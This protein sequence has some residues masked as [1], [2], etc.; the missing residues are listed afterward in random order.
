MRLHHVVCIFIFMSSIWTVA[1]EYL[2]SPSCA[3]GCQQGLIRS[4]ACSSTACLCADENYQAA[5]SSCIAANCTMEDGLLAKYVNSRS[6]GVPITQRYPEADA[7]TIIPFSIATILFILRMGA[8][9]MRLGGGWGSDDYTIIAAYSLAV[10]VFSVNISMIQYGFGKN[11][12]DIYPQQNITKAYKHFYAF[13]LA[14]KALMSLAKISVCLFLLRIFQ[15]TVFRCT[16]YAMIG[17][18]SAIAITWML[19]DSFHCI[20]VHLAWTQWQGLEHGKCVN[21]TAATFANGF[22]NIVVDAVMVVMPI[23][24]VSKLNLSR[25]KKIGVVLMFAS[26]LIL[27]VVGIVRVVVFSQNSSKQNPTYEMEALNRW[28]VIECQIAIICACLPASRAML[29][30]FFPRILGVSTGQ[31]STGRP[32]QY[33]TPSEAEL[34]SGPLTH[35]SG[36]SKTVAYSVD[37]GSKSQRRV[38]NGFTRLPEV[39][40]DKG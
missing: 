12:W 1:A 16:A 32:H 4:T 33:K 7:G 40:S 35:K 23:Y 9:I 10:V 14:Y 18:N 25:Q 5:L 39:E 6:C 36:I 30:R 31:A 2:G 38:S 24:E 27:T 20:P 34:R 22:V 26:G 3:L 19:V 11:V 21:F 28:S 8:K 29:I 13:V 15:S 17:I 37:Y